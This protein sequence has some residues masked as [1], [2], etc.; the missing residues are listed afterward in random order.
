MIR[1]GPQQAQRLKQVL[2]RLRTQLLGQA[3]AN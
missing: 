3:A 2:R 1:L